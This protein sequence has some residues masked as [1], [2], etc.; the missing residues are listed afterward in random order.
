MAFTPAFEIERDGSGLVIE[1]ETP[2]GSRRQK[3]TGNGDEQEGEDV[4]GRSFRESSR[5]GADGSLLVH[6][7]TDLPSGKVAR[8]DAT[9][10]IEGGGLSNQMQVTVG[11]D[12]A[13]PYR[14]VFSRESSD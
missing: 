1:S 14:R 10:R 12:E 5:W 13:F 4:L 6:R 2:F 11:D 7:E 9:W 3:L 8:V